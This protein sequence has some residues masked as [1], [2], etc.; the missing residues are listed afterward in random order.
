MDVFTEVSSDEEMT[1][2]DVDEDVR[3][4]VM[5]E[6]YSCEMLLTWTCRGMHI[7]MPT[8]TYV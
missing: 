3:A 8:E 7:E 1:T 6:T 5:L 2:M 4:R